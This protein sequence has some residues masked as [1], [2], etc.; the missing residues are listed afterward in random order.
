M[1]NFRSGNQRPKP[2]ILDMASSSASVSQAA[3]PSKIVR[4]EQTSLGLPE[5]VTSLG[6]MAWYQLRRARSSMRCEP[7]VA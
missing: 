4:Y 1:Y 3:K 6:R 7:P 2:G 5:S